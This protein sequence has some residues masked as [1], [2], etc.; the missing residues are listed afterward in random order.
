[1][2]NE[3][4]LEYRNFK[5]QYFIHGEGDETVVCLH[6][7]G[8]SAQDFDFIKKK[9]LKVIALN[10]FFHGKSEY[11]EDRIE[12]NP[13]TANEF[14]D[15]FLE[16]LRIE[17]I[18]DFHLF[19]FSQGG[20]FT[21]CTLPY[22]AKR[23]KTLTL[24]SPDGMDNNS[25]YNWSSRQGWAR[26]LFRRWE[27][28][29][30]RL[31]HLS[32]LALKFGIMRPKVRTFVNQFTSSKKDFLRASRTW[33]GFRMLKPDPIKIGNVIRKNKIPFVIIMGSYDQ[34]IRPKQAYRFEEKCGLKDVV[35]EIP[36]GHNFF[37]ESSINKFI[38]LLPFLH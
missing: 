9:G 23:V 4:I 17:K 12:N 8:R 6:G 20:R 18:S 11:P 5:Q 22:I 10:L 2:T 34:V 19:A 35:R 7:H 37:K 24:I 30:S 16:L 13:I 32:T 33:R 38:H 31:R 29:P 28:D 26:A 21:L 15:L 25:F 14:R 36:N 1:M 3:K 27:K